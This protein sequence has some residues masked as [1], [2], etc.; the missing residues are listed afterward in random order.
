M[1]PTSVSG[2]CLGLGIIV[3]IALTFL[4]IYR[5]GRSR[6]K[7]LD[8]EDRG[9]WDQPL[10]APIPKDTVVAVYKRRKWYHRHRRDHYRH[11]RRRH[12]PD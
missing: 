6:F 9:P 11:H 2:L 12:S 10:A 5:L 4:L 7:R 8:L 3:G 1:S